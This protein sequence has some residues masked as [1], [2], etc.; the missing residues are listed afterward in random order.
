MLRWSRNTEMMTVP[1]TLVLILRCTENFGSEGANKIRITLFRGIRITFVFCS[2]PV[3]DHWTRLMFC[4]FGSFDQKTDI[5][6]T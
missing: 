2:L 1:H 5:L 6:P 3:F 4:P